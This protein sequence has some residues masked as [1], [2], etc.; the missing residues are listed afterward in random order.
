MDWNI[1]ASRG[2]STVIKCGERAL[3]LGGGGYEKVAGEARGGGKKVA[4]LDEL[5]RKD[6]VLSSK[7]LELGD[8]R[9]VKWH[10]G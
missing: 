1:N 6:A 3:L 2:K 10:G 8:V 5:T 4:G 9:E 7:E